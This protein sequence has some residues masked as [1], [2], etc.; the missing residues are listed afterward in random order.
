MRYLDAVIQLL[1]EV[2]QSQAYSLEQSALVI[3]DAIQSGHL[4]YIFGPSHASILAQEMFY[5]AVVR[6]G[7]PIFPPGLTTDVR[8]ITFTTRVERLPGYAEHILSEIPLE[9]G[10]VLIV[11]SV[12]GRNAVAVE[13]A[14][15]A[16][17]RG[18]YVIAITGLVYSKSVQPQPGM[19][20]LLSVLTGLD[21][22][23]PIGDGN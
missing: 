18:V 1:Q 6:Y 10:D 19:S 2:N 7:N 5:R 11:H 23:V 21:N 12:S 17:E 14:Q 13:I 4:I 3:A 20:R 22:C 15:G 16:R 9:E 8:P